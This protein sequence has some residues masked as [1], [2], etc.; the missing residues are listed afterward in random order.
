[1]AS[2]TF[3]AN[4]AH[5]AKLG[6]NIPAEY[7]DAQTPVA[8]R[9][10]P[11][12]AFPAGSLPALMRHAQQQIDQHAEKAGMRLPHLIG[13]FLLVAL[14]HAEGVRPSAALLRKRSSTTRKGLSLPLCFLRDIGLLEQGTFLNDRS[15]TETFYQVSRKA[16]ATAERGRHRKS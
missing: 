11:L 2:E 10:E 5:K 12:I 7:A 15:Y 13:Y 6:K 1:V 4:L 9:N 14:E 8:A 16:L 3:V